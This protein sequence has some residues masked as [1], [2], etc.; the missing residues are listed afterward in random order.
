MCARIGAAESAKR[1]TTWRA[2]IERMRELP[3]PFGTK[4]EFVNG[5]GRVSYP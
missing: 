2:I 5:V 1:A 4:I 3:E